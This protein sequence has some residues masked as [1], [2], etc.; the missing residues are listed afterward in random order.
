V[1]TVEAVYQD[2]VFKPLGEVKLEENQRVKLYVEPQQA[3]QRPESF[4]PEWFERMRKFH[5]EF[6]ER[7]GG[8]LPDS[9]DI[10]AEDRR[11]E[12]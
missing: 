5:Q 6:I 7:H 3:E 10:I 12:T 2:G 9:T 11:R 1:I 8:P 4:T